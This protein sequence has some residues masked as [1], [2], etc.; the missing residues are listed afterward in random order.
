[1]GNGYLT[2][3][4]HAGLS[5]RA[6]CQ[7][8]DPKFDALIHHVLSSHGSQEIGIIGV[9]PPTKHPLFVGVTA[10]IVKK[11]VVFGLDR[12]SERVLA[13]SLKGT[14]RFKIVG[15]PWMDP[16]ESF[17]I[18]EVKIL[19]HRDEPVPLELQPSVDHLYNMIPGLVNEWVESLIKTEKLS[20]AGVTTIIKDIGPMPSSPCDRAMWVGALLNP[21]LPLGLCQEIRPAMLLCQNDYDRLVLATVALRSTVDTLLKGKD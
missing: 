9:D 2:F 11:D 7:S 15:E 20:P 10:P 3:F 12:N 13:T 8:P 19:D 1:L 17:Y 21:I 4:T 18:G 5:L 6:T 14:R 16:T